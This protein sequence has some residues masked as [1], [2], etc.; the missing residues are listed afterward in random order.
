[1]IRIIFT[2]IF[3]YGFNNYMKRKSE[4]ITQNN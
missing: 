2:Y 3:I 1:L 4:L